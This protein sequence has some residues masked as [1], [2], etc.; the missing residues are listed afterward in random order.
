MN[1]SYNHAF[2][3]E[4]VPYTF[5]ILS[6][7]LDLHSNGVPGAYMDLFPCLLAPILWDRPANIHPLVKLLQAYIMKGPQQIIQTDKLVNNQHYQT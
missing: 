3:S 6:L 2:L 5:Q 4:F 7:L 1:I